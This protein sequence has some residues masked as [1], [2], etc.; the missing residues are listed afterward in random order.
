MALTIDK[1]TTAL[2]VMD[3]ENDIV[4]KDGKIAMGMGFGAMVEKYGT[5]KHIR[6]VLDAARE[7]KI[8]IIYIEVDMSKLKPEEFPHRG[9]FFAN[10]AASAGQ[11]LVKGTWGAQIHDD[12]K[13]E[14][15]E[16][17]IGKCIVSSFCRSTLDETLKKHGVT[18]IILTGVATTMV[19][20]A[21]ARDAVDRGYS[22]ITVEN[23]VTSFSDEAHSGS[24][25]VLR[26]ISDVG[27]AA[28]VAAA[29]KA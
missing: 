14:P 16:Y 29:L 10:L 20:E 4:H 3:C 8:P 5:L 13:P 28:E 22:C 18:D 26:M 1:K 11:A 6:T 9:Q 27:S 24:I 15:G 19:V 25:A 21:T 17:V 2:L 23:A 12:V 7:V